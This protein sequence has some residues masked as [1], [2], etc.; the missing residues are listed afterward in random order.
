MFADLLEAFAST[1]RLFLPRRK[2]ITI[3]RKKKKKS[4]FRQ[5]YN[6]TM[7][8]EYLLL[9]PSDWNFFWFWVRL[10]VV[11]F[12]CRSYRLLD[13]VLITWLKQQVLHNRCVCVVFILSP[14]FAC[15]LDTSL[16]VCDFH[17]VP[18]TCVPGTVELT[19]SWLTTLRKTFS[20]GTSNRRT[21]AT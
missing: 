7:C 17:F 2:K 9:A 1:A 5:N 20:A 19:A 11:C 4:N 15:L 13:N 14:I 6:T 18:I 12:P 10:L 3:M 21:C 8:L 16:H